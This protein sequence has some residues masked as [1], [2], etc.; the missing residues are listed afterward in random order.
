[1]SWDKI[2]IS[3]VQPLDCWMQFVLGPDQL[4]GLKLEMD[5]LSEMS[6]KLHLS[7]YTRN[8][9]RI[10]IKHLSYSQK[11]GY[12][13]Q[14]FAYFHPTCT[15]KLS[16][17][18]HITYPHVNFFSKTR[19]H[20]SQILSSH[21]HTHNSIPQRSANVLSNRHVRTLIPETHSI[22]TWLSASHRH[23]ISTYILRMSTYLHPRD[24]YMCIVHN[25]W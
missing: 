3:T 10:L 22:H 8:T 25:S 4:T 19:A 2:L 20:I 21:R 16:P 18:R 7:S 9:S 1:M 14:K 6:C 11:R 23:F 5:Q 13:T 15:W 12:I 17:E 24:I